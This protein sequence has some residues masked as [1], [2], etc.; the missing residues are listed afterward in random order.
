M[1]VDEWLWDLAAV[2]CDLPLVYVD[3]SRLLDDLLDIRSPGPVV[4]YPYLDMFRDAILIRA[5]DREAVTE[6][7]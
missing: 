2:D 4:G 7:V 6:F 5:F 3:R 1:S